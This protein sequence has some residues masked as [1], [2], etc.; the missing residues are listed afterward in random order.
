ML[1]IARRHTEQVTRDNRVA[2]GRRLKGSSPYEVNGRLDDRF[3]GK[4]MRATT[5]QPKNIT[6]QVKCT[7]LA[8]TIREQFVASNSARLDLINIFGRVFLAV[9]LSPFL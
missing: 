6:D 8:P 7:N 5:L 2:L 3:C 4:S 1:Q 9:N